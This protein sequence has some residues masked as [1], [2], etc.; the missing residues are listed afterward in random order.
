MM[1]SRLG[2]DESIVLRFVDETVLAIDAF[3][4]PSG[5]VAFQ[6]FRLPDSSKRIKDKGVSPR[7]FVF[8]TADMPSASF[9][10]DGHPGLCPGQ[11]G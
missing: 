6:G 4:P 10:D 9:A 5:Q 11:T 8:L 1:I 7:Y 2:H 3:G